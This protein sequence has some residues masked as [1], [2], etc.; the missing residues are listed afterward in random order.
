MCDSNPK[1]RKLYPQS[2]EKHERNVLVV[3][4]CEHTE[5]GVSNVQP[6][7]EVPRSGEIQ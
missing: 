5:P 3:V 2:G 7:P 6:E 1:L 4:Y